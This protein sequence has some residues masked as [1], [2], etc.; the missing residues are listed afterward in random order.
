V[1]PTFEGAVILKPVFILLRWIRAEPYEKPYAILRHIGQHDS[2]GGLTALP[3]DV[4]GNTASA[5]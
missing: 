2:R 3:V 1:I 5:T 4:G